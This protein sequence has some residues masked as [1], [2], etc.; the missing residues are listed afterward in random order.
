MHMLANSNRELK[1]WESI[2]NNTLA[3]EP[4]IANK[5]FEI[6]HLNG[7]LEWT[8]QDQIHVISSPF[9]YIIFNYINN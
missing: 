6:D 1:Y 7:L 2:V 8:I 3:T 5:N 9:V 4:S